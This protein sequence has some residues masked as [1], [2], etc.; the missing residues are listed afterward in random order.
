MNAPAPT[1]SRLPDLVQAIGDAL[2]RDAWHDDEFPTQRFEGVITVRGMVADVEDFARLMQRSYTATSPESSAWGDTC[3]T[4]ASVRPV[5]VA[6][7]EQD[8]GQLRV[9]A[10]LRW[11]DPR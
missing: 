10:T 6:M 11:K 8:D 3:K 5:R 1:A 4:F 9:S 2:T 7:V